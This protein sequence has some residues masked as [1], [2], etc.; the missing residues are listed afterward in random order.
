M[1][2]ADQALAQRLEAA[3]ASG[4]A[5][6]P[7][8]LKL[9]GSSEEAAV[10]TVA[11]GKAVYVKTGSPLNRAVGLGLAGAVTAEE[12][13]AVEEFYRSR[14]ADFCFD[15]CPLADRSLTELLKERGYRLEGFENVL[16]REIEAG[17]QFPYAVE[18]VEVREAGAGDAEVW[19]RTVAKGFAEDEGVIEKELELALPFHYVR[20]NRC[21]L[22]WSG[23]EPVGGGIVWVSEGLASLFSGSTLKGFRGRGVQAALI[24]ARLGVGASEGCG[25]AVVKTAPG[26]ASQRN[27]ERLGF[28]LAYTKTSLS[29][30]FNS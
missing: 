7:D 23:G 14:N 13:D 9:T 11:G 1:L 22:A 28:R 30:R 5:C 4:I 12:L 2:F 27:A 19:A 26:S 8:A 17:E 20:G 3:E 10:E 18:G 29:L 21:F 16:F 24:R 15:L 6:Y 25:T